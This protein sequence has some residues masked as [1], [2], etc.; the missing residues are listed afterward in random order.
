MIV[1]AE[2]CAGNN[3]GFARLLECLKS[4][5]AKSRTCL[6]AGGTCKMGPLGHAHGVGAG[7]EGSGDEE[8]PAGVLERA[9]VDKLL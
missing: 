4:L 1:W 6:G 2:Q 7:E 3:A 8:G 9:L 5:A